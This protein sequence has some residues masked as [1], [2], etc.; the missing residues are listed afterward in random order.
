MVFQGSDGDSGP[1]GPTT[2]I[3]CK[4]ADGENVEIWNIVFNEYFCNGSRKN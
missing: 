4:N 1:C 3:Y 2:E